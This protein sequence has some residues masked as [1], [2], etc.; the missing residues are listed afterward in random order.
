MPVCETH[1]RS[2]MEQYTEAPLA[3]AGES[4]LETL[5]QADIWGHCSFCHPGSPQD[6]KPCV[7][8]KQAAT[9]CEP[10]WSGSEQQPAH[11]S[12]LGCCPWCRAHTY[13]QG[14]PA[15]S[16]SAGQRQHQGAAG[17]GQGWYFQQPQ[18]PPKASFQIKVHSLTGKKPSQC[19]EQ[20]LQQTTALSYLE[21]LFQLI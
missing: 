18:V 14:H 6:T 1:Q 5:Q 8:Q 12:S 20:S 16:S 3:C 11:P 17:E 4:W 7:Q 2:A 13:R 21:T 9:V 15:G 10:S 19:Q